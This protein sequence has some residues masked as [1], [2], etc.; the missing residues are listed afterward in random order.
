MNFVWE[1]FYKTDDSRSSD[2]S[3]VGLGLYIVKRII[4]AHDE[5]IKVQCIPGKC[6]LFTFTIALS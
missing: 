1:R 6:T 5:T 4:D 3:G 2:K